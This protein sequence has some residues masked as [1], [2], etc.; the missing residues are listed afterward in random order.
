MKSESNYSE[1][2]CRW[3]ETVW[4]APY[5]LPRAVSISSQN[6]PLKIQKEKKKHQ[7]IIIKRTF[8]F[9]NRVLLSDKAK[10]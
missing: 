8:V 6:F 1:R 4:G 7:I 3:G 2:N 9:I 5:V 10:N